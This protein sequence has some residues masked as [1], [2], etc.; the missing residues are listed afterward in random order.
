MAKQTRRMPSFNGVAANSLA[1]LEM[2]IGRTY[3]GLLMDLGGTDFTVSHMNAIRLKGDGR[4]ILTVT[5]D[6]LNSMNQFDGMAAAAAEGFLYLD[7]E[8]LGL[9]RRDW[10]EA[11]AIGTGAARNTNRESADYNPTPLAGMQLEVDI[12]AATVPTLTAKAVQSGPK[13]LGSIIK[14]RRFSYNTGGAG[15]YEIS[16]IPKGDL[17][18]R[19]WIRSAN[20]AITNVILE[21]DNFR[22]FERTPAENNLIQTDGQ[23]RSPQANWFV[24]D[25]SER[26]NG[27]EAIV[28]LVNDFRLIVDVSVDDDLFIYVDYVGGLAGN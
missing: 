5:G 10:V 26:G 16:D 17:V 14:R 7:F 21:R 1:T 24:I 28:T 20:D 27:N 18:N 19:I 23:V 25:P 3:H 12:G 13:P 4:E 6:H 11:T 8:R 15:E 9:K 22:F 2:P